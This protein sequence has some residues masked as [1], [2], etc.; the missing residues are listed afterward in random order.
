MAK[1]LLFI[2]RIPKLRAILQLVSALQ[3]RLSNKQTV[4]VKAAMVTIFLKQI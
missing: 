2:S 1:Q 4:M 3:K